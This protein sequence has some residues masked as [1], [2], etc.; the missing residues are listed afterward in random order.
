MRSSGPVP[1]PFFAYALGAPLG[2]PEHAEAIGGAL[3]DFR[4]AVAP[5]ST[6]RCPLTFLAGGQDPGRA[7][8]PGDAARLAAVKERLDP[9]DVVIGNHRLPAVGP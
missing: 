5:T 3:L 1:E 4:T 6:D 2:G 8:R 7:F 9:A